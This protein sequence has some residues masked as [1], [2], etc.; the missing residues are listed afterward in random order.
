MSTVKFELPIFSV[1]FP[2]FILFNDPLMLAEHSSSIKPE[3]ERAEHVLRLQNPS[4]E[5]A[6]S[7]HQAST[8]RAPSEHV[9]GPIPSKICPLPILVGTLLYILLE[10]QIFVKNNRRQINKK[11]GRKSKFPFSN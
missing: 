3:H 4:T 10:Y 9:L 5:R 11:G 7:E 1:F 8:E 6:P 2:H